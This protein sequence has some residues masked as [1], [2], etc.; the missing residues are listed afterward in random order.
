MSR[1][2]IRQTARAGDTVATLTARYGVTVEELLRKNGVTPKGDQTATY[3]DREAAQ[4]KLPPTLPMKTAQKIIEENDISVWCVDA[5]GRA[6]EITPGSLDDVARFANCP[7]GKYAIFGADSLI[8]LPECTVKDASAPLTNIKPVLPASAQ[9]GSA[10]RIRGPMTSI[11]R[12]F[13]KLNGKYAGNYYLGSVPA[14]AVANFNVR[15]GSNTM[16]ADDR[17]QEVQAALNAFGAKP[18]LAVDGIFG[19]LTEAAVKAFQL[20]N[21]LPPTGVVDGPTSL[22]LQ[23]DDSR[24]IGSPPAAGAA[25]SS[26]GGMMGLLGLLGL[27]GAVVG[28]VV[29]WKGRTKKNPRPRRARRN[30]RRRSRRLT[31]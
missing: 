21:G 30:G 12:S 3:V 23:D 19:D 4:L 6:I 26:S 9:L 27:A 28:G 18:A 15:K 1:S 14:D 20:A 7:T 24:N 2:W 13:A 31:A 16:G 22:K 29:L 5:G 8:F 17:V 10:Q 11:A 25:P